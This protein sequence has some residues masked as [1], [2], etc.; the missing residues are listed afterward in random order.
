[1]MSLI[2]TP[3]LVG[4]RYCEEA[5]LLSRSYF[6]YRSSRELRMIHLIIDFYI[7]YENYLIVDINME[8][9]CTYSQSQLAALHEFKQRI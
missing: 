6:H 1:M 3:V 8:I 7:F 4:K 9:L 5:S 2:L